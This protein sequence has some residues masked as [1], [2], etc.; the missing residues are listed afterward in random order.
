[1]ER[2]TIMA[3]NIKVR[4]TGAKGVHGT[5][6][7]VLPANKSPQRKTRRKAAAESEAPNEGVATATRRPKKTKGVLKTGKGKN[8]S[9]ISKSRVTGEGRSEDSRG[10]AEKAISAQRV[11]KEVS[12]ALKPPKPPY[13][14]QEGKVIVKTQQ[15][16]T[17]ENRRKV[18]IG[19]LRDEFDTKYVS[20][21]AGSCSTLTPYA[22]WHGG[23]G[24]AST[25][26]RDQGL[27]I[28]TKIGDVGAAVAKLTSFPRAPIVIKSGWSRFG[29]A[30]SNGRVVVPDG[31]PEPL[32]AFSPASGLL[33]AS[34]T[35]EGWI[36]QVATPIGDHLLASF[37]M[38]VMFT[39]S[40]LRFTNRA[41]NFGFELSGDAGR[42]KTTLQLLMASAAGPA[43][44]DASTTYWRSLNT[45]MNALET[46][47]PLYAD[48][49]LILDEAGLVHGAGK[50]DTRAQAM[51]EMAFRL[52][53]GAVKHRLGEPTGPRS[54]LVFVLSTNRPIASLLGP[55]HAAENEAI[56]DRLIT[57]PLLTDRPFGIFDHCP[58][59]YAST[60]AFAD[61][62]KQGASEHYGH[63]LPVFLQ[64][65]V[66]EEAEYPERL[67]R[68]I[69]RCVD[70]FV[71]GSATDTNDG[72][73]TRVAKAMGL[74]YAGGRAAQAAGV[75]PRRYRCLEA[76]Q[77]ALDLH[78][79]HGRRPTSFN[80]R[81]RALLRHPGTIDLS[82]TDIASIPVV[83]LQKCPQFI[84]EGRSKQR[85][86]VVPVE[87]IDRV[88]SNWNA[89]R[90]DPDVRQ[91]LKVSSDRNTRDR[92]VGPKGAERPVYCFDI[93]DL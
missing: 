74:V 15:T 88:F 71:A 91:R 35:L 41:D 59:G 31:Q 67:R 32:K 75:L 57:L 33:D 79:S 20:C 13:P 53:A 83:V 85:E 27:V 47:M 6:K 72:S 50:G 16:V 14:P 52:A 4:P 69:N 18:A 36:E 43:I 26:L 44:G 29:F 3:K 8:N 90:N 81:L 39:A 21:R 65:L 87:Q 51:R 54:R 73:R 17:L 92:P 5:G 56:A 28:V 62:L 58:P 42:G 89:S 9:C 46:V 68:R 30:Q 22:A 55:A 1:M 2:E 37:F 7:T 40:L 93:T 86:L 12:L 80:D 61:V 25:A 63:A 66:N 70:S 23:S 34:G 82:K 48:M 10:A 38:M 60:G 84:Y 11:K 76:A 78:I 19:G 45:T 64:Y 24:G 77:A 49:P